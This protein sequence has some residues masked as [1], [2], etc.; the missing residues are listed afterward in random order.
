MENTYICLF[1]KTKMQTMNTPKVI[2]VL[3]L[4]L[5]V[6]AC[7]TNP[8]TGKK[9]LALVS[10]S[11]LFPQSF[12]L[13]Q[14][15]LKESKVIRGTAEAKMVDQVGRQIAEA[16]E[17]FLAS[18][19]QQGYLKD[20]RWEYALIESDQVNAWCMPGGKIAVYSGILPLTQNRAGLAVVMG[21]EVSH[22]LLNHSQQQASQS[23]ITNVIGM[24]GSTALS[25]TQ[26]G[27]VFNQI[28]GIG[29]QLGV[30]LPYSRKFETEADELGLQ[31]MAIAGYDPEV[32]IAF[33]ERMNAAGGKAPAEFLS[34]HP[35]GQSRINNL[36]GKVNEAKATA[37]KF[38]VTQFQK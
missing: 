3:F 10:N 12:Q 25:G 18:T 32:A 22:A 35:S 27:S 4:L 28:Y 7:Q 36:K 38:G 11:E 13:Y 1:L 8:F 5:I 23:Q 30:T 2:V 6:S 9:G 16:A 31:L 19:G 26:F 24:G 20:Y 17:K 15:T 34:T 29:T 37:R 14:E 33:W 21:H